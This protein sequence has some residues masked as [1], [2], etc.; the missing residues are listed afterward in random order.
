MCVPRHTSLDEAFE[1]RVSS[2][3]LRFELGVKLNGDEARMRWY[4]H[5]FD[6]RPVRAG[7]REAQAARFELFSVDVVEFVSVAMSLGDFA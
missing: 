3:G 7:S 6:K 4:F 5:D 1:Q 2:G